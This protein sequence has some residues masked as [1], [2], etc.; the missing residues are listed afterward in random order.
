MRVISRTVGP[1]QEN[2][3]LVVDGVTARAVFIDPGAE[4]DR[5]LSLLRD[6]GATLDAIWLTHAH[7]DHIGAIAGI[8][9]VWPVPVHLHR[10]DLPLFQRANVQAAVYGVPFEQPDP[11]DAWLGDGD[12]LTVGSVEFEVLHV[13]GHAPG[14]VMFHTEGAVLSGDLLFAG[15]IGRTDLP[16]SDPVAM[17]RSLSR[18]ADLHETT[19]VY[20]G[21]GPVTSVGDERATNPFLKGGARVARS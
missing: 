14:H 20:P 10:D 16:F 3:Y 18:I 8:R 15:S 1:F 12:R 7:L 13:P 21:H 9:R 4:P 2:T 6:S 11:P 17:D 19:V 5:L